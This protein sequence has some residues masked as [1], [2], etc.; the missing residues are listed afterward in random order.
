MT[1]SNCGE[2]NHNGRGCYKPKAA[3]TQEDAAM[4][5]DNEDVGPFAATQAASCNADV[6]P[7]AATQAAS[8]NADVG[9]FAAAQEF[10]PY[11]P[12]VDNEEDPPLRPMIVSETQSRIE[13]G[14]LRGPTTGVRKIKFAGDHT[15]ASTPTNLPYSPTKLTWK[16]K[17]AISSSQ[18][19]LEAR[20][21]NIK[22]MAIKGKGKRVALDDEDLL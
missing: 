1:C 17:A 3:A 11:G 18:V 15:G 13:R 6:G 16:G 14:N 2:P 10:T 4:E 8:C 12:E 21:R 20:K 22:M 19:Q 7:F 9:P 5:S